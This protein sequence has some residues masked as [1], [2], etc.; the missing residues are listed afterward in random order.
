MRAIHIDSINRKVSVVDLPNAYP[1]G[2]ELIGV[3]LITCAGNVPTDA[4]EDSL[5]VD[6]EGLLKAPREYFYLPMF[7]PHPLAGSGFIMGVSPDGETMDASIDV[8]SVAESVKFY[9][10]SNLV[11]A[12]DLFSFR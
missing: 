4:G 5:Y 7:C 12:F 2:N 8:D 6:D 9:N 11:E 3:D 1:A 10:L